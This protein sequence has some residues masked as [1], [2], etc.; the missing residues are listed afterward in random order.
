MKREILQNRVGIL[1][2][3][4]VLF[5]SSWTL[6]SYWS[7]FVVFYASIIIIISVYIFRVYIKNIMPKSVI[8]VS[9]GT[10]PIKLF[11]A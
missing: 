10:K 7:T 1:A 4:I 5:Y 9:L 3:N 6:F 11:L 2:S 8:E